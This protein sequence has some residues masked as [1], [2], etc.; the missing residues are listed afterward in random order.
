MSV[1]IAYPSQ[2]KLRNGFRTRTVGTN[3]SI[4]VP[5]SSSHDVLVKAGI[6]LEVSA[7]LMR[8]QHELRWT[9]SGSDP[10][11]CFGKKRDTTGPRADAGVSVSV[12]PMSEAWPVGPSSPSSSFAWHLSR[13]E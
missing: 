3:H 9:G 1:I 10:V 6:A 13:A 4:R 2:L 12:A 7:A 5:C 8:L 11:P